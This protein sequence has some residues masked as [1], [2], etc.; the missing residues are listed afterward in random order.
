MKAGDR[1]IYTH[2]KS[3]GGN[4]VEVIIVDYCKDV[5]IIKFNFGTKK[6]VSNH[7]LKAKP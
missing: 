1:V 7:N 2:P 5:S 6:L 4:S 3:N